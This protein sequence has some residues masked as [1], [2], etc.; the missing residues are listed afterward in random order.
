MIRISAI[1]RT[2]AA[3]LLLAAVVSLSG[4]AGCRPDPTP[5]AAT[6]RTVATG[7]SVDTS[8][9]T[10][11][12]GRF[13][14]EVKPSSSDPTTI[15]VVVTDTQSAFDKMTDE[16]LEGLIE[17][18]ADA[19]VLGTIE[20]LSE[21]E[22]S[23]SPSFP[24]LAGQEYL[25]RFLRRTEPGANRLECRY[26]V[27][28]PEAAPAT[29]ITALYPTS[30]VLPANHLK[31][32]IVFSEPMQ[33][34]EIWGYFRLDDLDNNRP[35]PRPFRHTELWSR[36]RKTLTLW[37]H[38]GRVKQGVNLNVELGAIL[39]EGRRY[40]LSISGNWPS[41]R[42]TP[43]GDD[44]TRD[45]TAG[46]A[47]HQQPD[48]AKWKGTG[49]AAHSSSPRVCELGSPLDWALLHSDVRVETAAGRP[50]VGTIQTS[51]NESTWTFTPQSEWQPGR[52]RLAVG[53]VLE[54]L[55]GNSLE[56]PFEVDVTDAK[57]AE[58]TSAG[59]RHREFTIQ[60]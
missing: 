39:V 56:R 5:P 19:P 2:T 6:E 15:S 41:A 4:V 50:V 48:L 23:F 45:F 34:G 11:T 10:A 27:A 30:T 53:S 58:P 36:D 26:R 59:T 47:D 3:S 46:P 44:I 21:R 9:R 22:V 1:R 29:T 24:L 57:S 60:P 42:G 14:L 7:G 43:L 17:V 37:F 40:R 18:R 28:A 8:Y 54:D 52:Y 32:Y 25:V 31:F 35:V 20:K 49:P 55:A 13:T 38:P 51:N 12:A 33:P 16:Q